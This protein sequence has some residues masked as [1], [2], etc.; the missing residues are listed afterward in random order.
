MTNP[1][2]SLL[3]ILM[4]LC[5]SFDAIANSISEYGNNAKTP[6]VCAIMDTNSKLVDVFNVTGIETNK[7]GF[8][9][10]YKCKL[11]DDSK[12]RSVK[13]IAQSMLYSS[14]LINEEDKQKQIEI[15]KYLDE[16]KKE[17][18]S[19]QPLLID[20]A[21]LTTGDYIVFKA[22]GYLKRYPNTVTLECK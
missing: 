12:K 7:K 18:D 14:F 6:S 10:G 20:G 19:M 2:F 5:V 1:L 9:V 4:L 21:L 16:L 15:K 13:L 17:T 22:D 11:S 3:P 8:P